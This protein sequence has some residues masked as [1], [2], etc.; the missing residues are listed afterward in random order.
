[1]ARKFRVKELIYDK[2]DNNHT[3]ET[4]DIFPRAGLKVSDTRLDEVFH[5]IDAE[6]VFTDFTVNELKQYLDQHGIEYEAKAK[7]DE[8]LK[9]VGD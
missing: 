2:Q 4:G 5:K 7:K 1:M 8:L 9:L 6:W 3:Y